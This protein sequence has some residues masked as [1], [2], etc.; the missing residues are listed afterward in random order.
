LSAP[1]ISLVFVVVYHGHENGERK[2][3]AWFCSPYLQPIMSNTAKTSKLENLTRKLKTDTNGVKDGVGH[4][5]G[6]MKLIN[7]R[8][9]AES[10]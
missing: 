3:K 4:G 7:G 1:S 10:S 6:K 9:K 2:M 5:Y 8:I